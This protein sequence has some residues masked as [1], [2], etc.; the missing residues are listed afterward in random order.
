VIKLETAQSKLSAVKMRVIKNFCWRRLNILFAV[1]F[2]LSMPYFSYHWTEVSG[3]SIGSLVRPDTVTTI[4]SP[5]FQQDFLKT[6][7]SLLVVVCSAGPNFA[8]RETARQSWMSDQQKLPNVNVVFLLGTSNNSSLEDQIAAEALLYDDIVQE[9][10]V[11]TYGNLTLKSIMLLK[12]VLNISFQKRD[13]WTNMYRLAP[14]YIMKTDDDMYI[15]LIKLNEIIQQT[16]ESPLLLGFLMCNIEPVR[17]SSSKW[18]TS[19][20]MFPEKVFPNYL[21][22]G[23][24]YLIDIK[25][26]EKLYKTSLT[27][28]FFYLEDVFLTGIVAKRADIRIFSILFGG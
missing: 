16:D 28:N 2:I 9:D 24:S 19:H 27:M 6:D 22:G 25:A 21:N 15:N 7:N 4:M 10:F 3:Q 8:A 23:A 11:D 5:D 1:I 20:K 26:A 12:W 18:F 13:V 14:Q 17:N